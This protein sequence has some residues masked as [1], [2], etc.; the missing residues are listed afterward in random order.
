MS[1]FYDAEK[2]V[3][4]EVLVNG[5]EVKWCTEASEEEGWA[6]CLA[7]IPPALLEQA[8]S[9]VQPANEEMATVTLRG[10]VR[11]VLRDVA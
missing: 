8:A 10:R 4:A 9:M 2:S 6:V 11:I 3:R 1:E 7:T 5:I